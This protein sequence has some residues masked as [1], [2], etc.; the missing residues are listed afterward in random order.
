LCAR[1]SSANIAGAVAV[2]LSH[3][4]GRKRIGMARVLIARP[5]L[6]CS[7]KAGSVPQVEGPPLNSVLSLFGT[8]VD[9][10]ENYFASLEWEVTSDKRPLWQFE[11]EPLQKAATSF[12]LVIFPH[13]LPRQFPIG[14]N[15]LYYKTTAIPEFLTV[16]HGGWG[17]SLSFLPIEPQYAPEAQTFFQELQQRIAANQSVF[18][19]PAANS[20]LPYKDYLLFVCQVPHDE[21]IQFHSQVTVAK[22]LEA[23]IAYAERSGRTLIVKGHPANRNSMASLKAM[24][25]LSKVGKWVDDVSIH[26]CLAGADR[27]FTVNSGVGFEAMLHAK[28]VV[29]FGDAEYSNVH[30][31]SEPDADA[32]ASVENQYV[33]QETMAA[34]LYQFFQNAIRYDDKETYD[35]VLGK[36]RSDR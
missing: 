7:F 5:R 23:V 1:P 11:L 12:D 34:F 36:Y 17:A 4:F 27:V 9:N 31:R 28:T 3:S 20:H 30:L 15:A 10:L 21:T 33:N 26:T 19:Q 18:A 8:F 22:A 16:D 25:E 24:T 29:H 35:R 32:I 14:P 13:K 6:D 2:A